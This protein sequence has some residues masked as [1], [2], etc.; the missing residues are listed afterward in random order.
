MSPGTTDLD[1]FISAHLLRYP[2]SLK[3]SFYSENI[4]DFRQN[5]FYANIIF[6]E[7]ASHNI[8]LSEECEN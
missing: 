2:E 1:L 6:A 5:Y 3:I 4:Y 8:S 7:M